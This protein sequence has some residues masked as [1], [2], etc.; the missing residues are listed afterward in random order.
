MNRKRIL[1]IVAF[2]VCLALVASLGAYRFLSEKNQMAESAKLQTV[3]VAVAVVD[4]PLGTTI[5]SNQIGV[6]LWPRNLYPKDAFTTAV[7]VTGRI[8]MRDFQRGEPIVESKLSPRT[9]AA[10]SSR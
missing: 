4:I 8:A 3:G 9:R 2:A 1:G 6:S 5:N 10:A 7:P